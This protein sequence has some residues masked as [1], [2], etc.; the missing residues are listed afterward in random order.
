MYD[1]YAASNRSTA[2][3]ARADATQRSSCAR[4]ATVPVGLFGEHKYTTSTGSL[5]GSGTKPLASFAGSKIGVRP[6]LTF[7][8]TDT[9]YTGSR[10]AIFPARAQMSWA[11]PLSHSLP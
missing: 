5:G 10:T 4:V 11:L 8:S 2:S 1:S 7:E 9:R 6:P 3:F